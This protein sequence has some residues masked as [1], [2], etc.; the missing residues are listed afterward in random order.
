MAA[1]Q[2]VDSALTDGETVR[3]ILFGPKEKG[4]FGVWSGETSAHVY[5]TAHYTYSYKTGEL[6]FTGFT[7]PKNTNGVEQD[8]VE[9][10][11]NGMTSPA[12]NS[13]I[14]YG[15]IIWDDVKATAKTDMAEIKPPKTG[16][17][18]RTPEQKFI[19]NVIKCV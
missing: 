12:I 6:K 10:A 2:W 1:S 18:T 16:S 11:L 13:Y 4:M 3:V 14:L 9:V 15:D 19:Y 17:D 8:V 7:R 5:G